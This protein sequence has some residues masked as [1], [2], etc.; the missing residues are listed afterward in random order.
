MRRISIRTP[1]VIDTDPGLD[2]ALALILA[3]RSSALDVRAIT[4]VAGNVSVEACTQNVLRI[5]EVLGGDSPPP[6]FE[7][8]SE[9]LSPPVA[10]A[11]H[12]HAGDGIGGASTAFPVRQLR[13]RPAHAVDAM[14]D[15]ARRHS[16]NLTVIALGPLT[17]VA[18]A[19]AK[20]AR[21]MS[22]IGRLIIMGGSADG[23]GNVT[24]SAEFNFYSDPSAARA[25]VRSGMRALLVGLNVT[26]RAVLGR[27]RFDRHLSAMPGGPLRSF[28]A[29]CAGPYFDFCQKYERADGCAL[30]DPLAVAAAI[31]PSLVTTARRWCD[32]VATPGLTRGRMHAERSPAGRAGHPIQ[33]AVAVDTRRFVKLFLETACG[34]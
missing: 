16:G 9:P 21:A 27:D 23:R 14:I 12:V 31:D 19:L 25:V 15:L 33:V 2:D 29:A 11:Q 1:V 34:L 8:C 22:S 17:N 3:L 4:S 6:V 30:H 13:A 26:Q 20:D 7:G 28:L 32:V 10:R 18:T 24:P 5:L